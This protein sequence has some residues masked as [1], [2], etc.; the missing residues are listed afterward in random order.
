M[1]EQDRTYDVYGDNTSSYSD[2]E[3]EFIVAVEA[4]KRKHGRSYPANT[5]LLAIAK[6]LGYR[7]VAEPAPL[8]EFT[9]S[10]QGK[11]KGAFGEHCRGKVPKEG[12]KDKGRAQP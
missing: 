10:Q 1:Q 2:D 9:R 5:E 4:Y 3:R 6:S 11:P 8:P 12:H 7:K